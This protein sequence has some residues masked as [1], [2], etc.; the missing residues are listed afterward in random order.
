MSATLTD[1]GSRLDSIARVLDDPPNVHP[2]A[3][4]GV[5]R[6]EGDDCYRF[7]AEHVDEHSATLETGLGVSTALFASWRT[8]HVC[9]VNDE[10]E[11]WRLQGYLS[12]RSIPQERLRFVVGSSALVL[13]RLN[14][15]PLDLVFIDGCHGFPYPALDWFYASRWLGVG[16]IVVFDDLQ[17]P[18]VAQTIGW[19][20]EL[21]PRWTQLARTERWG[22]YRRESGNGFDEEWWDQLFLGDPRP[23]AR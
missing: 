3:P 22:A 11:T 21:D 16:G 2:G 13:P 20:L 18:A 4:N 6:V 1:A 14:V 8:R 12:E 9:I 15:D 23:E 7:L 5:W 19:F 10:G 17:I